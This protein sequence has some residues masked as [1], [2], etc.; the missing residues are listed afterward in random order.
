MKIVIISLILSSIMLAQISIAYVITSSEF[1]NNAILNEIT[2]K[3]YRITYTIQK[4]GW[5]LLPN[6][7]SIAGKGISVEQN[8]LNKFYKSSDYQYAF[9][10]F[11]KKYIP[12]ERKPNYN[13]LYCDILKILDKPQSYLSSL[14]DQTLGKEYL[15]Y[16][17]L[18]ADWHY[19]T[20]PLEVVYEYQPF[21]LFDFED[22]SEE[23]GILGA[24][25]KAGWN[26]II[27]P[28]YLS[29]GEVELGNCNF[30]KIY[31]FDD[32][33]Q[34]WVSVTEQLLR[35]TNDDISGVG[36]AIKVTEDCTLVKKKSES[37][38]QPPGVPN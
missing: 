5:Y 37:S 28:A 2:N 25:L 4:P 14:S 10:P 6:T 32:D 26:I 15:A 20:K 9:S 27:Y 24:K 3:G 31:F 21:T 12:C 29:H 8:D 33:N 16:T 7:N 23:V 1:T 34:K 35:T 38:Q 30:E 36:M 17:A 13:P 18:S 22:N 19:Y 11:T